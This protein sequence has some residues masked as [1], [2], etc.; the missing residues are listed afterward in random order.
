MAVIEYVRRRH[1]MY[2]YVVEEDIYEYWGDLHTQNYRN[3]SLICC[4]SASL[5]GTK[6]LNLNTVKQQK[7]SSKLFYTKC[8]QFGPNLGFSYSLSCP[9]KRG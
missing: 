1:Y 9:G 6:K 8:S 4:I 2:I 5:G 7:G 3:F